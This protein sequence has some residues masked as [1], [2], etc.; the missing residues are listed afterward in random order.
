MTTQDF[1]AEAERRLAARLQ[2]G[3]GAVPVLA[4]TAVEPA[5]VEIAR[6][7]PPRVEWFQG[8]GMPGLVD[9]TARQEH[10]YHGNPFAGIIYVPFLRKQRDL[11]TSIVR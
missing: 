11:I 1:L 8:I 9:L 5:A 7:A 6:Q 10:V 3:Y 4:G 2:S